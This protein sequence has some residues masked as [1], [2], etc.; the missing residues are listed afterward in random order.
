MDVT[1]VSTRNMGLPDNRNAYT[2]SPPN[3]Q[4][5][6]VLNQEM[7]FIPIHAEIV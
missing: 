2:S 4:T 3:S 5:H 6:T 7:D 1:A